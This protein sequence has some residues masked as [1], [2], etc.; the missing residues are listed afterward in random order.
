MDSKRKNEQAEEQER[1]LGLDSDHSSVGGEF[2][3]SLNNDNEMI[4]GNPDGENDHMDE[5]PRNSPLDDK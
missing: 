3:N 4:S 5:L 1:N 2:A